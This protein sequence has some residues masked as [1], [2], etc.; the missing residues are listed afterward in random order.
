MAL[1]ISPSL[2]VL[3]LESGLSVWKPRDGSITNSA[4]FG[5]PVIVETVEGAWAD[6]VI[7]GDSAL[8]SACI[9]AS[10]RLIQRGA[11]VITANCGFFIRH[12]AAV[13]ASVNVPVALSSLLLVPTLLRLLQPAAKLAVVVADSTNFSEDLLGIDNPADRARVVIGGIEGGKL[14]QNEMKRPPIP[15]EDFEIER[16]VA[17]CVLRLRVAHPEIAAIL[18][19]CTAFP[20][21]S[22]A[23]RQ[24][25]GLPVYDITTLCRI[26][27][28]SL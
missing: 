11:T 13:A 19:E 22:S 26:T 1:Q 12:Q 25:T 27:V 10:Q 15:T 2:G 9:A 20:R 24:L 23:I 3:N 17:A 8:A 18:F 6:V 5:F 14:L 7:R 28:A 4:T 16:D 21:I